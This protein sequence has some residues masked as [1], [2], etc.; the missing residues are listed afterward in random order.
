MD[1]A[2]LARRRIELAQAERVAVA[3]INTLAHHL[4]HMPLPPPPKA[5]KQPLPD[6]QFLW[7]RALQQRPDLA[8]AAARVR[9]EQVAVQIARKEYMPDFDV[10][11]RYDQIWDR[12]NQRGQLA[13]N[14]NV[15]LYQKR[16]DAAVQEACFRLNQR[17]AEYDQAVDEIRN[18]VQAAYE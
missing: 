17:R 14:M 15:P 5:I 9:A 1:L 10:G 18:D 2:E 11:G 7:Q 6:A 16:R 13:V 8:A 12:V 4:P 3:R